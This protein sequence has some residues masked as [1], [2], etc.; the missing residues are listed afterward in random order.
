MYDT[1]AG[2][3]EVGLETGPKHVPVTRLIV[4]WAVWLSEAPE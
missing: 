2:L 1:T 4:L 3:K